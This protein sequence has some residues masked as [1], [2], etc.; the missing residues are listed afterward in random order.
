MNLN[1]LY[2]APQVLSLETWKVSISTKKRQFSTP[3]VKETIDHLV[4]S[5]DVVL[6]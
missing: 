6:E 5:Q 3:Q 4:Y 1:Y 2:T